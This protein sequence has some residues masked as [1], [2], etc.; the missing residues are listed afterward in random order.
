MT[1][2]KFLEGKSSRWAIA[3]SP[4]VVALGIAI[5]SPASACSPIPGARPAPLSQRV[6]SAPYVFT[7]TVTAINDDTITIQIDRYFKGQGDNIAVVSGFNTHSCS[8]F[9]T[10]P[11][12]DYLFFVEPG[13]EIGSWQA[14]Y[15][16]AFGSTRPWNDNTFSELQSLGLNPEPPMVAPPNRPTSLP[17]DVANAVKQQAAMM[18]NQPMNQIEVVASQLEI[19]RNQ[20]EVSEAT[21]RSWDSCLGLGGPADSCMRDAIQGWEIILKANNTRLVYHTDADGSEIRLNEQASNLP[22]DNRGNS[23]LPDKVAE[24]VQQ[25]ARQITGNSPVEIVS[26]QQQTWPN[27]CLGIQ[28]PDR[29]CTMAL[30]P[31]WQVTVESEGDRL[32]FRTDNDGNTIFLENGQDVLPERLQATILNTASREFDIPRNQIKIKN[33]FPRTWDGCLGVYPTP[34]TACTKIAIPGWQI[35]LEGEGERLVYHTNR[36]GS[37]IRF[38]AE[39]STIRDN[40]T[41]TIPMGD[42]EPSLLSDNMVFRA[43]YS[44]GLMGST[45]DVILWEDGKLERRQTNPGNVVNQPLI[46]WVSSDQLRDFR[47]LLRAQNFAQYN[48]V[49]FP[50]PAGAADMITKIF[51]SKA[52]SLKDGFVLNCQLSTV[53][54]IG[55]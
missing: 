47:R 24:A 43:T 13:A 48:R 25:E 9:I 2:S 40:T 39:A 52:P 16:G 4:L 19:S 45:T 46:Q 10:K 20:I 22:D 32:V 55:T 41:G 37:D 36:D 17:D 3:L 50:P 15:D 35:V 23:N 11:G 38:N 8:D 49:N 26:A 28:F 33:A 14:L 44:G 54:Q 30:V 31:G 27:G 34:D 53:G 42:R 6:S 5:A 29:A 21:F 51:G 7:G 18:T 1:T 12:Q